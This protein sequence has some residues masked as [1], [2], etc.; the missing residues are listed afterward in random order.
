MSYKIIEK[1]EIAYNVH[2][3]K[4]MAPDV[5]KA[6]KAGQF[7]LLR[8]EDNG[9]RIPLTITDF[10]ADLGYVTIIFQ[11]MGKTT[12][13]LAKMSES[14]EIRDFVGPLGKA[15]DV[16]KLGTVILVG[17][18]VGIA[19]IYP[20]VKAYHEA[21][22][23]VIS[24]IGARNESLLILEDEMKIASDELHI[25]TDDGSK[26]H[27]GF[28]TD[29]VKNILDSG[30]NVARIVVIGPP[31]LMRVAAGMTAPYGVETLV[32]LNPIMID[33]TGMCGGCRVI[34][35]NETKFACVD[36]PEFDG[37]KVDFNILMGRLGFYRP[38]ESHSLKN[39]ECICEVAN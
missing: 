14:D 39:H 29:I 32:S 36:G 11:E 9:E 34:V 5:A 6:A 16:K 10:D 23:R 22:N 4:I 20:Q 26:G 18:G 37:H 21:G 8:I 33:G 27:H 24:V 7:I 13:Q 12:K 2:M 28:V 1:K 31:I 15:S 38:E 3:M 19:P 30:E 17:G 25:A 35:D